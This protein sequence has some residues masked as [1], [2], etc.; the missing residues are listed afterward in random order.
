MSKSRRDADS[1]T[2]SIST[3]ILAHLTA[4]DTPSWQALENSPGSSSLVLSMRPWK[5][6]YK[7][8]GFQGHP[9]T[10]LG[11]ACIVPLNMF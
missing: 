9:W 1:W 6:Q 11:Q 4:T 7:S 8:P 2:T 10:H 5:T 3:F